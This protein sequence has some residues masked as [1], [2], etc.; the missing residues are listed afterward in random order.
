MIGTAFGL[1]RFAKA[2][3]RITKLMDLARQSLEIKREVVEKFTNEGLYPYSRFYLNDIKEHFSEY[4]RNHFNTIGLNGLNECVLNFLGKDLGNTE[5]NQLAQEIL[6]FMRNRL[7]DYQLETN[8]LYN[9]EAT[10]AE[11]TPAHHT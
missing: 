8:N 9:L 5:A 10:P 4:W 3:K 1:S 11:G 2:V 6:E 7:M